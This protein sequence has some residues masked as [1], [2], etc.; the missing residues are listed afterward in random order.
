MSLHI[1]PAVSGDIDGVLDAVTV[2]VAVAV[3]LG[4]A[5]PRH[6]YAHGGKL[7][8]AQCAG[9]RVVTAQFDVDGGLA[10]HRRNALDVVLLDGARAPLPLHTREVHIA[11]G[12]HDRRVVEVDVAIIRR[13]VELTFS[14]SQQNLGNVRRLQ[15]VRSLDG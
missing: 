7:R 12:V 9:E 6:A 5:R 3:L 14:H 2:G 8:I 4:Q 15:A 13:A 1:R 10:L 11:A